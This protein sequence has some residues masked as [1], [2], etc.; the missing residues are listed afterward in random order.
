[1]I[2]S[3]RRR[4]TEA[5]G[6]YGVAA[7]LSAYAAINFDIFTVDSLLYP[8]LNLTGAVALIVDSWPDR[9]WQ[10]IAL[11]AVWATVAVVAVVH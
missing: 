6:W 2:F 8:L 5:V 3:R 10:E 1:M 9:D 7:I 11:N 4:Y